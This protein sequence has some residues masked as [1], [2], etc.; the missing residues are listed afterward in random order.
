M[1]KSILFSALALGMG[2]FS[3]SQEDLSGNATQTGQSVTVNVKLPDGAID[4]ANSRYIPSA[5]DDGHQ[6]RCILLVT[7]SDNSTIRIEKVEAEAVDDKFSFTFTPKDPNNYKCAF[8]ADFI[9]DNAEVT[10][11]GDNKKY[12]DLYYDTRSLPIVSYNT[13]VATS[14]D[15]FNNDDCDA[16]CGTIPTG[17]SLS[18]TLKR[19]FAKISFNDSGSSISSADNISISGYEVYSSF[20]IENNEVSNATEISCSDI[21]PADKEKGKTWF[22]N[23]VFVGN[24]NSLPD[25]DEAFSMT[26]D[27]TTKTVSFENDLT[28]LTSNTK[29]NASFDWTKAES[30]GTIN[31]SVDF[32][33]GWDVTVDPNAPKVGDY[34]YSDGSWSAS[35][36]SQKTVIG[37]VFATVD[38][39]ASTDMSANYDGVTFADG[40]I[41]GWVVALQDVSGSPRFVNTEVGGNGASINGIN[42]IGQGETDIRGYANCQSWNMTTNPLLNGSVYSAVPNVIDGAYAKN[43]GLTPPDAATDWYLPALEQMLALRD[44]YFE[45]NS[46]VSAALSDAG[47]TALS[48]EWYWTST[49]LAN[50]TQNRV[51][52]VSFDY[53]EDSYYEGH[54]GGSGSKVRPV[55]TF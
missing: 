46:V 49:A 5:S 53:A 8:W 51:Y 44:V 27:G 55:L 25:G 41:H 12:A 48:T 21:A 2:L 45:E 35:L 6:L 50:E 40:E 14:G 47:G 37:V 23:Y 19:P 29:V 9:A 38:G 30:D 17:G 28:S 13:N 32:S 34:Y 31:I 36:S 54:G 3:C 42:G 7:N 18:V 20:D 11:E 33:T 52:R 26:V 22:Y 39:D 15:L 16:Y 1:K 43:S 4:K 10:G 24:K